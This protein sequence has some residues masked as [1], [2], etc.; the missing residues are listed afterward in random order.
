VSLVFIAV[1]VLP[2]FEVQPAGTATEQVVLLY[3]SAAI[4]SA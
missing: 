1:N 2:L 4:G 3:E